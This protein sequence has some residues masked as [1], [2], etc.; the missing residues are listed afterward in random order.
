MSAAFESSKSNDSPRANPLASQSLIRPVDQSEAELA[1][2]HRFIV[3]KIPEVECS[4][5]SREREREFCGREG[6]EV[7]AG[8]I[9]LHTPAV[10]PG[11]PRTTS[12]PLCC[13]VHVHFRLPPTVPSTASVRWSLVRLYCLIQTGGRVLS[14]ASPTAPPPSNTPAPPN[15]P[16]VPHRHHHVPN[17]F[18]VEST[19]R[20]VSTFLCRVESDEW[21]PFS[22]IFVGSRPLSRV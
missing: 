3:E 11:T 5:N 13:N 8:G 1:R 15:S 10:P 19:S 14:P 4:R 16:A 17:S 22:R 2:R 20:K 9:E 21:V 6:G 12:I 18:A 7:T